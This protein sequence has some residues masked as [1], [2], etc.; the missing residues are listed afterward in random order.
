MV[1]R[2]ITLRP[3]FSMPSP[4]HFIVLKPDL[5]VVVPVV[6][7]MVA[8]LLLTNLPISALNE[9][10]VFQNLPAFVKAAY[11]AVLILAIVT[12]LPDTSQPFIYF[13]F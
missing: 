5:P 1:R 3:M 4:E 13:Q 6:M 9:K 12:F 8:L 7:I 2:M 10:K 11:C